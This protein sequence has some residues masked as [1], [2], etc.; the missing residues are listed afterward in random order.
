MTKTL[1]QRAINSGG[2]VIFGHLFSQSIRLG[3]NLI[4]T[5]LLVPEMFGVMAIVSVVMGGLAMFSDI[6]LLQNIVQSKRGEEPDY[7]NTAWTIQI[8]RGFLIYL[9]ALCLSVG[10]YFFGQIGYLSEITVYGYVDL[11][12]ILALVS[13]TA[14]ISSFNSIHILLLKRKLMMGKLV[15]IEVT[16]QICGFIFTVIWALYQRDIWALVF[17]GIVSALSKMMLSHTLSLGDR[18]RFHWDKEAVYEIFHFGK[19][20]FLTSIF[21]FL[22]NSGDKLFLGGLFS[23]EMLGIYSIAALMIG[24]IQSFVFRLIGNVAFPALSEVN[25]LKPERVKELYYKIRL[26]IDVLCLL[27]AGVFFM[28]GETIVKLLYDD[29][30]FEAGTMLEILSLGLLIMRFGVAGQFYLACGKPKIMSVLMITKLFFMLIFIPYGFSIN[31][32]IGAVWGL[33]LAGVPG[34]TLTFFY[35][36]TFGIFDLKNELKVLPFFAIGLFIGFVLN[37]TSLNLIWQ[38]LRSWGI[39][40]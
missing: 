16:S 40:S 10:L 39:N 14:V 24:A 29:R 34:M 3:S 23:T 27:V 9:I 19:W 26:P 21:G 7:L 20:M 37:G 4:L 1:K 35:K 25:R 11:P 36:K 38:G 30:Y 13:I 18:C 12:F 31:Q 5:R 22:I 15:T 8:F 17:G 6:G 2:W 32:H 28:S 33:V